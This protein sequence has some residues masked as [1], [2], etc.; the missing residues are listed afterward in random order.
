VAPK[1]SYSEQAARR[2]KSEIVK[3][4]ETGAITPNEAQAYRAHV[5]KRTQRYDQEACNV[6]TLAASPTCIE[7]GPAVANDVRWGSRA[8]RGR[9][10]VRGSATSTSRATFASI[11]LRQAEPVRAPSIL[12]GL[13]QLRHDHFFAEPQLFKLA[14]AF[15]QDGRVGTHVTRDDRP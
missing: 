11:S 10:G 9:L 12:V 7:Q 1:A 8:G 6:L 13:S 15:R 3:L 5:T 4:T 2:A 14:F